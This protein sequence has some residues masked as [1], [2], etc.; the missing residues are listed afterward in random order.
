MIGARQCR[1]ITG[2]LTENKD[3]VFNKCTEIVSSMK[4]IPS[5]AWQVLVT[6]HDANEGGELVPSVSI[7]QNW[8]TEEAM[9]KSSK[10]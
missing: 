5:D 10:C 6:S 3:F 8:R 9:G 4:R 2:R 1:S 7:L